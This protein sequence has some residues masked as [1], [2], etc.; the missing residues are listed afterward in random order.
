VDMDSGELSQTCKILSFDLK[1]LNFSVRL[2]WPK[3]RF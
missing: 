2:L 1:W 3:K